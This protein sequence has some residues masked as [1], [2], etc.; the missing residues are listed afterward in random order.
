[1]RGTNLLCD[2]HTLFRSDWLLASFPEFINYTTVASQILLASD[3][4]NRCVRT[5]VHHL[6]DPRFLN[7][8]QRIWRV[9]CKADKD[10]M[11]AGIAE[12]SETV[13]LFLTCCIPQSELDVL[14]VNI[15]IGNVAF[16]YVGKVNLR[17]GTVGVYGQERGL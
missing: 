12:R 3:K 7:I 16:E 4:N 2:S 17:E 11:G 13:V 14:S 8:I 5:K 1:V 9:N 10:Y 6:G 15:D